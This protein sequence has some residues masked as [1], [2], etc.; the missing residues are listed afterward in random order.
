MTPT[1]TP[2]RTRSTR[3]TP[4]SSSSRRAA[5]PASAPDRTAHRPLRPFTVDHF[6]AYTGVAVLEDGTAFAAQD[7]QLDVVADVFAGAEETWV[8]VPEG[9]GKTTLMGLVALYHADYTANAKCLLAAS[10]RDQCGILL[11]QAAGF[12]YRTPSLKRRFRVFEGY[13]RIVAQRTGGRIQVFAADDRT[14]DGVIFT[15]AL[16]DE[17][18]R[19]R[20]MRLYRTW[21]GK[22]DK[23]SGQL[24]GISTAGEPGGEF[25]QTLER[26]RRDGRRTR[27]RD[28]HERIKAGSMVVHRW[29][30]PDDGDVDDLDQVKAANPFSGITVESLR[31][32]RRRKSLTDAHWR[33]FTCN[34]PVRGENAAINAGEWTRAITSDRPEPGEPVWCGVDLGWTWDTTAIV[35]LWVPHAARHVLLD[36]TIIVPPRDGTS[37][38]PSRVQQALLDVHEA[39]P[40]HTVVIDGAAGGEQ[41]A[42]WI[43]QHLGARVV[44]HSNGNA[45]Q[46]LAAQRFYEGLRAE[47]TPTLQHTGHPELTSHVLNARARMLPRGDV[48][49]DRPSQTRSAAG[50]EQRVIDGLSAGSAVHSV[51]VGEG[52]APPPINVEDYRIGRL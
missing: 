49:F 25:E 17:M 19:H 18:H 2:P 52:M 32:K 24:V 44:V 46:A 50:Q 4:T 35:P 6:R 41:L 31:R 51:A 15:L 16:I 20:D 13:R 3:S 22:L 1:A 42:E 14:G 26:V 23:R 45:A 47:P 9:N 34:Q 28:G 48:V 7:F 39:N 12:V 29:A 11:G 40:V 37:T 36:P 38:P 33:R 30:V 43:E 21:H 27:T 5:A 8:L 10:S